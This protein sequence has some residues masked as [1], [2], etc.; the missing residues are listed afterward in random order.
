MVVLDLFEYQALLKKVYSAID[1]FRQTL[2]G[3][4]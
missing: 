2:P 1:I 3:I 4:F